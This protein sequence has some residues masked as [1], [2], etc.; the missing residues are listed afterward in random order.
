MEI[1]AIRSDGYDFQELDLEVDD[2]IEHMLEDLNYNTIHDFSLGNLSLL[3]YW[4]PLRT[5]FSKISG[6]KNQIPDI[7]NWIGAKVGDL[8]FMHFSRHNLQLTEHWGNFSGTF[9]K[10]R[11]GADKIPD[12]SC[13]RGATLVLSS[14]AKKYVR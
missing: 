9:N 8:E 2:F 1:Y 3:P 10:V 14:A 13:W 5:G 11:S 7:C 6:E 12:I 4:N